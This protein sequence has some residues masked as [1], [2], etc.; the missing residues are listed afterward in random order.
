MDPRTEQ[1]TVVIKDG[2]GDLHAERFTRD[3][4]TPN[5]GFVLRCVLEMAED[6]GIGADE[7]IRYG[8]SPIEDKCAARLQ[9]AQVNWLAYVEVV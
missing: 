2:F 3:P 4:A 8:T 7:P 9:E 6:L 5:E 1:V